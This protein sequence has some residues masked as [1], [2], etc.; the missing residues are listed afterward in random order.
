MP[1]LDAHEIFMGVFRSEQ[2]ISE[3]DL[4]SVRE[5]PIHVVPKAAG[6]SIV[7]EGDRPQQS[8]VLLDGLACTF[9][10][11]ARGDRQIMAVHVRGDLPDVQ[12]LHLKVM[13]C[14]I[15]ALSPC[16]IGL[17]EH[18]VLRKLSRE[19]PAVAAALWRHTLIEA[20]IFREWVL[21]VGR[22]PALSRMAHF[23]CE[24]VVRLHAAEKCHGLRCEVP[25]TQGALGDVLGLSLVHVNRT[26]MELRNAKLVELR[27]GVL[28]VLD[29]PGLVARGEFD[30]MYLHLSSA[31]SHA[32]H[33]AAC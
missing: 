29:W 31:G 15:G 16:R 5:I 24:L 32:F 22:R 8:F 25:L 12:S 23:F 2:N 11:S 27:G 17:I 13:D 1:A 14:S 19:S 18:S 9:K 20:A 10:L 30:P 3:R 6:E 26:L 7:R 33:A 4:A 28:E 21:N